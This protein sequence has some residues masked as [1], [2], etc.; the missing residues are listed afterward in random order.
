[1][2]CQ[3]TELPKVDISSE[4]LDCLTSQ[5]VVNEEFLKQGRVDGPVSLTVH[6]Q[7]PQCLDC[8]VR[9]FHVHIQQLVHILK[10]LGFTESEGLNCR[11]AFVRELFCLLIRVCLVE[12]PAVVLKEK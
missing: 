5:E 6:H 3:K 9:V 8:D 7:E 4:K 10:Q 1:M 2:N 11:D 12:T